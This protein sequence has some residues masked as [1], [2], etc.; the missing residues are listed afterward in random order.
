[1]LHECRFYNI[2]KS[3]SIVYDV[4]LDYATWY[5]FMGNAGTQISTSRG[6]CTPYHRANVYVREGKYPTQGGGRTTLRV[7]TQGGAECGK[8][9]VRNCGGFYVHKFELEQAWILYF[10]HCGSLS[11]KDK[12]LAPTFKT[13]HSF[14]ID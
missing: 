5:R 8:M 7:C 12:V 10:L 2:L 13:V 14:C 1:M 4:E 6:Q 3:D 11:G 9:T